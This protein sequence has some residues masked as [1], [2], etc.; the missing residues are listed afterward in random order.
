M[1]GGA[2]G[3]G[4]PTAN[5]NAWRHG[6]YSAERKGELRALRAILAKLRANAN[7]AG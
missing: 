3:S 5:R 6:E 4:A 7:G 2:A 1:H